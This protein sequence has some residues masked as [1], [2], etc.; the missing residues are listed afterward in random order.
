MNSVSSSPPKAWVAL[1]TGARGGIGWE[2]LA[3]LR[4]GGR[5][6]AAAGRDA[7]TLAGVEAD[8]YIAADTTTPERAASAVT[9]CRAQLGGAP[10]LLAH[11][12]GSTLIAPLHR[13]TAALLHCCTVAP[14]RRFARCYA[15]ISTDP[16]SCCQRGLKA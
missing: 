6:A 13:C 3:S 7:D 5:R 8:A 1:V 12:V 16:C 10:S 9:A 15:S 4:A 2:R 14:R 11:C